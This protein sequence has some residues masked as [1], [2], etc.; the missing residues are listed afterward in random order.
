MAWLALS[1][2]YGFDGGLRLFG[3]PWVAIVLF[4]GC[5]FLLESLRQRP[6][7][8]T[9]GQN[10]SFNQAKSKKKVLRLQDYRFQDPPPESGWVSVYRSEDPAMVGMVQSILAS[11]EVATQV[12][13]LHAASFFPNVEGMAMEICVAPK[14]SGQALQILRDHNLIPPVKDQ[15]S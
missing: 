7:N 14:Q 12:I 2:L 13:N 4:F 6:T 9:K 3:R 11:R 15:F 10:P 5:W 1:T 8:Q